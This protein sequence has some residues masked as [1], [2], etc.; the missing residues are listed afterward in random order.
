MHDD[1]NDNVFD[2]DEALDFIIYKE[3]EKRDREQ[4][5]NKG[6]CLGVVVL[7]LL[8]VGSLIL[9]NLKY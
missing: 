2:K 8:P 7:L 5:G 3:F 6:G 9:L 1:R 4:K